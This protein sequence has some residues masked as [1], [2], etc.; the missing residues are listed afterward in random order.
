LVPKLGLG[1]AELAGSYCIREGTSFRH[2]PVLANEV[3]D[4]EQKNCE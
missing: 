3:C 4:A 1:K 2:E